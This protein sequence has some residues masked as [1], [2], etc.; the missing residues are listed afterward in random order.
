MKKYFS[1]ECSLVFIF[2][3]Q[4]VNDESFSINLFFAMANSELQGYLKLR[5]SK[6]IKS[7]NENLGKALSLWPGVTIDILKKFGTNP[8]QH[9]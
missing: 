9:G 4:I 3:K 7:K 8:W 1:A 5:N 2:L 6:T